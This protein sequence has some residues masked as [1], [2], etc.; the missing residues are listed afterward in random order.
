MQ[1]QGNSR[2]RN[3]DAGFAMSDHADWPGLLQAIRNHGAQR[4]VFA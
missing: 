3:A 4:E 1:V 2:R